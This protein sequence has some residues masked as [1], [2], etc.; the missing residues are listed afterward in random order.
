MRDNPMST[1]ELPAV[2]AGP[3][4]AWQD[5]A[6]SWATFKVLDVDTG[7]YVQRCASCMGGIYRVT[8]RHHK[9]YPYSEADL[10]ALT[11]AHLRMSHMDLDPDR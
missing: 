3:L 7:S 8:D 11:V 9:P 2:A 1:T 4:A 5:M 10:L 6:R